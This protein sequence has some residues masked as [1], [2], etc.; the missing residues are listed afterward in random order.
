MNEFWNM[1]GSLI[2]D[3]VNS[4]FSGFHILFLLGLIILDFPNKCIKQET[5]RKDSNE[6]YGTLRPIATIAIRSTTPLDFPMTKIF[7]MR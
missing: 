5:F 1:F 3:D 2:I 7:E 6:E 4:K